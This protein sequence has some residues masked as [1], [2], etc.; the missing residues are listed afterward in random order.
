MARDTRS[1]K[2][3]SRNCTP[4]TFT[5]TCQP[6]SPASRQRRAWAQASRRTQSPIST[7]KPLCSA[8][9]MNSSG[10]TNPRCGC[11]HRSSASTASTRMPLMR[12]SR[13]II[14][15]ELAAIQR[16]AQIRLHRQVFGRAGADRFLEELQS[17]VSGLL[18]MVHGGVGV[19][20]QRLGVGRIAREQTDA[21]GRGQRYFL[22][23][24][25]ER[26]RQRQLYAAAP[27]PA[28]CRPSLCRAAP[29][30]IRRRRCAPPSRCCR[31]SPRRPPSC[32]G[33]RADS[34]ASGA[35]FP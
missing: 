18:A 30:R 13:L 16:L 20:D 19:L 24:E 14:Q 5:A 28:R 2:V 33:Y 12:Q 4:D 25:H 21:D 23:R 17:T 10:D 3:P 26:P 6:A 15:R 1:T 7:I 32:A 11:H 27:R 35:R 34:A 9:G 31:L 8:S 22:L 29:G